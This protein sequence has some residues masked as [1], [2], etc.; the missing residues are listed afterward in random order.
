MDIKTIGLSRSGNRL[1]QKDI[2]STSLP[3]KLNNITLN[4][5][6]APY[7]YNY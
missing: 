1:N 5:T 4:Y 6:P 7:E 3:L 2:T